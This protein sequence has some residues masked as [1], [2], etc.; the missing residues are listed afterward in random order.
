LPLEKEIWEFM[1]RESRPYKFEYVEKVEPLRISVERKVIYVNKEVL[2]SVI[3]GLVKA[4]LDWKEVMRKNLQHEK[5]HERYFKWNLKWKVDAANYGWLPSF[6]IDI[7]IDKIQFINDAWY[8]KWLLT[9][10]RHAF[11]TTRREV[12]DIVPTISA[13]PHFL[14]NQAAYWVA[15]GAI[16]LDEVTDLYPEKRDYIIEMSELFNR[17]KSEEDL[18]WAYPEAKGIYLKRFLRSD[19]IKSGPPEFE[20]IVKRSILPDKVASPEVRLVYPTS[21]DFLNELPPEGKDRLGRLGW[22]IPNVIHLQM[23]CL[24]GYP[25]VYE[26]TYSF[27]AFLTI[28]EELAYFRAICWTENY[29][30]KVHDISLEESIYH[31]KLHLTKDEQRFRKAIPFTWEDKL[32]LGR[33]IKKESSDYVIRKYGRRAIDILESD[34]VKRYKEQATGKT[35]LGDVLAF[36]LRQYFRENIEKYRKYAIDLTPAQLSLPVFENINESDLSMRQFYKNKF[37]Y[38]IPMK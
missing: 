5:A 11:E 3:E 37:N 30:S 38:A 17:I 2:I 18:E 19:S 34:T 36:W 20:E 28:P 25:P 22:D 24:G 12:W 31:E 10:A 7:V 13:R 33:E 29:L 14:Y 21:T 8:Q 6:L 9:D 35:I 27:F 16:T 32:E 15:I 23:P 4:G 26:P 1:S